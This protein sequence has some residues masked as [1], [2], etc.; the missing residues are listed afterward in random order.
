MQ[1]ID[2]IILRLKQYDFQITN[3]EAFEPSCLGFF[4]HPYTP[5]NGAKKLISVQNPTARDRLEKNY[6]P[7]LTVLKR[8]GRQGGFEVEMKIEFSVPKLLYGNNFQEV[9]EDDFPTVLYQLQH[10]LSEMWV[11]V[12]LDTLRKTD[13]MTIHYG[14]NF[15]FTDHT[16]ASS[17]ISDIS[18]V[19]LTRRLDLNRTQYRNDGKALHYYAQSHSLVLYDKI[20]DLKQS[21]TRASESDNGFNFQASIFDEIR[22][23]QSVPLEVLRM[24]ARLCA[25]RKITSLLKTLQFVPN[26]TFEGL[27]RR[28]IARSVLLDYW[29]RIHE[30][31]RRN[32]LLSRTPTDL[33]EAVFKIPDL[34]LQKSMTLYSILELLKTC[35]ERQI[36][37]MI[38]KRFCARTFQRLKKF[39]SETSKD[40]LQ[41]RYTAFDKIRNDLQNFKPVNDEDVLLFR[42]IS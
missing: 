6:K 7:R 31:V 30:E 15:C 27:F 13:V 42:D 36:Y 35:S 17:L 20:Q 40:V 38:E 21:E 28:N 1:M 29:G 9:C 4:T 22:R 37:N 19:D 11:K 25:R 18:K 23:K 3:Y 5:F 12:D 16:T 34:S 26:L 14:K 24:E 10:K 32:T 41:D 2:T 33:L 8:L 39:V